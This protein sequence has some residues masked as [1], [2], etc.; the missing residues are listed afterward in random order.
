MAIDPSVPRTR[1]AVLAAGVGALAATAATAVSRPLPAVAANGDTVTVG[2]TFSGSNPTTITNTAGDGIVAKNTS[3][4][5]SGLFAYATAT[6]GTTYG[7]FAR[8]DSDQGVG[9]AGMN[10]AATGPTIGVLGSASSDQGVGVWGQ[11]QNGGTGVHGE[12][13]G[14]AVRAHSIGGYALVV[15]GRARFKRC[16]RVSVAKNKKYADAT[17]IGGLQSTSIVNATI[18]ANRPGV[19]VAGV[20]LNYPALGK[21]RIYLTKV[22]STTKSTPV[23]WFVVEQDPIV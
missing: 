9:A 13:E 12:S 5:A 22:A 15:S 1:R 7:V 23:A 2:G 8:C 17:V 11:G 21:I 20:R 6:T 19:A 18:Q 10:Y 16:G 4:A 14:I 3:T